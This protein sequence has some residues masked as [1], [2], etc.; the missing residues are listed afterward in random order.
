MAKDR[1]CSFLEHNR[2]LPQHLHAPNMQDRHLQDLCTLLHVRR[3]L[4]LSHIHVSGCQFFGSAGS[5]RRLCSTGILPLTCSAVHLSTTQSDLA[6]YA[7][8]PCNPAMSSSDMSWG[9][10]H[11]PSS[12]LLCVQVVLAECS[13][14]DR[15]SK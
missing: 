3:H 14:W 1:C 4:S 6:C 8:A 11:S 5:Q 2:H 13:K 10:P 7:L 9:V 15:S 12:I